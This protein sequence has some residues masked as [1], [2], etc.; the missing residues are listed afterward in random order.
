[1]AWKSRFFE[2]VKK[3]LNAENKKKTMENAVI[4]VI[5]G[6]IAIIAGGA[7]F[8]TDGSKDR[9]KAESEAQAQEVSQEVSQEVGKFTRKDDGDELETRVEKGLSQIKGAGRVTVLITYASGNERVPA[10][11]AKKNDSSTDE[12]D[13][14]GGE[15]TI[16]QNSYEAEMV[17][18]EAQGGGKKPVF[19]KELTPQVKGIVVIAD[20]AGEPQV[21]EALSRAAMVLM[22]VPAHRI[23]VFEREE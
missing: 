14:G 7:F 12:K 6:I 22:D 10:V 8:T 3:L 9:N 2:Y 15:R 23:Q 18:E 16:T 5:I 11:N 13:S 17:Y 4:V 20:G 21:R 1:M 19:L